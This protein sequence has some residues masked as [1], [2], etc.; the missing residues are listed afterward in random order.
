MAGGGGASGSGTVP[1]DVIVIGAGLNG[2]TAA[3]YLA[4]AGKRVLVL[5]RRSEPGGSAET[6][7]IAPGFRADACAPDA[8]YLSPALAYELGL[9]GHGLAQLRPEASVTT[10]LPDGGALTLWRDPARTLA[11][12]HALSPADA[13]R[14]EAFASRMMRLAEV[15]RALY[16]APAPRPVGGDAGDLLALLKLGRRLRGLGKT[17]MVEFLRVLPMSAAELLDDWFESDALKGTLGASAVTGIFQGP[18]SGG[19]AFV[20][21]HQHVG[22]EAGAFRA[23]TLVRGGSGRLAAALA[24]AARGFGAQIRVGADVERVLVRDGRA[25]GVVLRGG[26]EIQ[27]RAVVSSADPRRTLLDLAGPALLDPELVHAVRAIKFRGVRALV[28]L[29]L[30]ELPRFRGV[31]GDGSALRGALSISPSL[32]YLERAFDDAKHGDVSRRP[33]LEVTIPT[34]SDDTRCPPGCHVMSVSVQFAPYHLRSGEWDAA[35]RESLGDAV[36]ATLAE[37]APGLPGAILHRRV[38]TPKDIED[39]YGLTEGSLDQGELTLDQIL[40]MRPLPGW[41]RYRTPIEGLHLCGAGT[42][43]GGRIAGGAGRLAAREIV[44]A[45]R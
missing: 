26:E 27:A 35:R 43:P 20:L 2:L 5:D 16:E 30:G 4:K 17:E 31:N 23:R 41:S 25:A 32:D 42:H 12:L 44:K 7:E 38:L 3:A 19:T 10:P 8:G 11:S 15:L 39:T 24:A 9:E 45:M 6:L 14:W 36:V 1:H 28:H 40:F 18:R 22:G 33:M 29:A 13:G 37:Y 34:L 21:L